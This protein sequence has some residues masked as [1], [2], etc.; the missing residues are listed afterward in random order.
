[1]AESDLRQWR[2][3]LYSTRPIAFSLD[4]GKNGRARAPEAVWQVWRPPYQ[5]KIWYGDAI[6]IKSTSGELFYHLKQVTDEN[7]C[8][9]KYISEP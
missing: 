7:I 3:A 6:L 9:L 8:F 4:D 1:M 5:S 2:H